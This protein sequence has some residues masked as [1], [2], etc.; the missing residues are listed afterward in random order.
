MKKGFSL[1]EVLVTIVIIGI[2]SAVSVASM[3]NY[4][5]RSYFNESVSQIFGEFQKAQSLAL[6]PSKVDVTSYTL[7]FLQTGGVYDGSYEI[8]QNN[9][10]GSNELVDSGKAKGVTL[11]ARVASFVFN[12]DGSATPG[13]LTISDNNGTFANK[14]ITVNAAGTVELQ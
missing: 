13:N 10:D 1:I 6:S 5:S 12:K 9:K 3:K 8:R 2:I 7:N 11:T 4:K 14:Q